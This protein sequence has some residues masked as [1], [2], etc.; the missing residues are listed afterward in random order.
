MT[1]QH[2]QAGGKP[3]FYSWAEHVIGGECRLEALTAR[4]FIRLC[5]TYCRDR[6][7]NNFQVNSKFVEVMLENHLL[8][9][10]LLKHPQTRQERWN[11]GDF[12]EFTCTISEAQNLE[13]ERER[14]ERIVAASR[15]TKRKGTSLNQKSLGDSTN[16]SIISKESRKAN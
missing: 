14:G 1:L 8:G 6:T 12:D 3:S 11:S 4:L 16:Y 2:P 15:R 5:C 13:G 7:T 9:E 10:Q